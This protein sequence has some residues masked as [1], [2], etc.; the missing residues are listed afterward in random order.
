LGDGHVAPGDGRSS[1]AG[2]ERAHALAATALYDVAVARPTLA[3]LAQKAENDFVGVP[4]GI[5]DQSAALLCERDHA[6]FIDTRSLATEQV[7]LDLAGH[8]L[9]LL[10]IDTKAP[11][12]LVDGEYAARRRVCEKVA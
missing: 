11:H 4:C 12:R 3:R 1:A 2:L 8:G 10:V 6:L 9:A 5:M 7:P